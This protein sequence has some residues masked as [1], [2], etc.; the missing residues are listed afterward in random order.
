MTQ[1]LTYEFEQAPLLCAGSFGTGYVDGSADVS[2]DTDGNW[3]IEA[4]TIEL[5]NQR[6]DGQRKVSFT[7]DKRRN[8][9]VWSLFEQSRYDAIDDLVAETLRMEGVSLPDFNH[10]HRLS[11]RQ[12]G[13]S[14][15]Y[16]QAAE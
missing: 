13:V 3:K 6:Y 8:G 5:E 4:I 2:F 14:V 10:E 9:L 12:L 11:A 16:R 15:G 7:L 1:T